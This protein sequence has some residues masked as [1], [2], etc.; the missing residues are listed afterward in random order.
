MLISVHP[1][2]HVFDPHGH[3]KE[4]NLG[5]LGQKEWDINLEIKSR[6]DSC[7][8][9]CFF[10]LISFQLL[11]KAIQKSFLVSADMAHALHPNYMVHCLV[12]HLDGVVLSD[13]S[14]MGYLVSRTSMKKIISPSCMVGL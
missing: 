2:S 7:N 4:Q 10:S 5:M 13:C 12:A 1:H 3:V 14:N 8:H 6:F 11:P 9:N